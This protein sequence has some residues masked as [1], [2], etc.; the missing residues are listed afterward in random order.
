MSEPER[1]NDGVPPLGSAWMRDLHELYDALD[2]EVANLGPVCSLSGRCCRFLE[3]GHT[4]FVS[5]AEVEFL[6]EL[7][8]AP[9]RELDQGATC[10]WQDSRGHCKAREARP[11]GC[12]I[13]HCD[14]AFEEELHGLS[15]RFI[16]RL[17][18]LST[19]HN[20]AWN[21][22]PLHRQLHD[23]RRRERLLP[24]I[25]VTARENL[26]SNPS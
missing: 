21:Y 23:E 24:V 13:Y 9:C 18:T 19:K 16:A 26:A 1:S 2:R 25:A 17:K 4:L 7:A 20:I 22:A 3:Y 11:L 10:P 6:L 12:R 15:E 8:S 5:T 14:P